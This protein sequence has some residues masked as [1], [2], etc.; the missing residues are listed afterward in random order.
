[1]SKPLASLFVAALLT[2]CGGTS[3]PVSFSEPVGIS[4]PV[5]SKDVVTGAVSAEKN[6]NTENGNPYGAFTS[7]ARARLGGR[8]PS[9]IAVTGATLELFPATS[10]GVAA[11]D[12]VFTGP[13]TVGFQ[14]SASG[15][16]FPVGQ[17]T[18]P[19]GAGPV[20]L[21]VAF[22]SASL[23]AADR[24]AITQGQFKVVLAGTAA[25]GFAGASATADLKVTFV[26]VA[27]E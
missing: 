4:L 10:T 23:P 13:V 2:A 3:D 11:L 8:D 16:L 9:H 15:T 27:Y 6:I 18:N 26:F 25:S 5:A 17:V 21:T 22:D 7:A 20:A 14:S 1:M 19:V 24:A 12:Q